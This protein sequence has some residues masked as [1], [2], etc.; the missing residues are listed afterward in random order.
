MKQMQKQVVFFLITIMMVSMLVGCS[1]E[2]GTSKETGSTREATFTGVAR[3][4]GGEV[5]VT[6]T[7]DEDKMISVIA[8]G[9]NE[10]TGIGTNALEKLP[11]A[12]LETN[13]ADV[14]AISGAT[15]TSKAIKEAAQSA[16]A[17]SRGEATAELPE[18]MMT[19]GTYV[20]QAQGYAGTLE[21][22]V[23]VS[24]NEIISIEL[25]DNIPQENEMIDR[26]FWAA[27][28]PVAMLRDTPQILK[29]VTDRLPDRIVESQSLAVDVISGATVSS[30]GFMMAVRDAIVQAGGNPAALNRPIEKNTAEEVYE[31]DVVIIG[32]GTSGTSAVAS[33]KDEG[34]SVILIEKSG[35]VGGTGSL[36]SQPMTLGASIQLENNVDIMDEDEL[37]EEWMAQNHWY[38]NGGTLRRFLQTTGSTVDWL[39]ERG[40]FNWGLS[41]WSQHW[42]VDYVDDSLGSMGV[43]DS[44][45]QLISDVDMVLYETTGKS[46]IVDSHGAVVGV[47]AEKYDGTKVTVN[48]KSVIIAT[49]GMLGNKDLMEQYNNGYSYEIF[50]LA[51]NIGEGFE[52]ALEA[53]AVEW[54]VG[55]VAAHLTDVAGRRRVGGFDI[56]DTSIPYTLSITPSLLKVNQRG[57]RFMDENAKA[58]SMNSSTNFVLANGSHN[59]T[60]VSQQQ[61]EVL[62]AEGLAGIGMDT[63][64]P[65]ANFFLQPLEPD[66]KME[67][68]EA[69][70]AAGEEIEIAYKGDTLEEL[71]EVTGMDPAT[72]VRNVE[73][74]NK[75]A[76]EG[77]DSYFNKP[78]QY[79]NH[80]GNEG[81]YYA[82]KAVPLAYS[83][84]GGVRVDEN[85]QALT[86]DGRPITGLYAVGVESIGSVLDG[87]AYPKLDG[88]AL[89]WGFNSGRIGGIEAG[90]AALK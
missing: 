73:R 30:S 59:F 18:L 69:V 54:N 65:G 55:G 20:G 10:T 11:E 85:M 53:G 66:Y 56:Y 42:I 32:G 71:A 36:S 3:G 24:E 49:G 12:I 25:T 16:I 51:Q 79:M 68:I 80:L 4:Y 47:I 46:L 26:E 2:T 82:I 86:A 72:F 50:G 88:V 27:K 39:A 64:P 6:I 33:A 63:V 13:S 61:V 37:F 74:Y 5:E 35:R 14:E 70:L 29:T 34:A 83:S 19:P 58:G 57:E 76:E 28:Y 9:D 8:I 81:P 90:K 43:A 48:A 31:A 75:M 52:M 87:V 78:V 21:V 7:F 40:G 89:G 67:N 38:V 84:L 23:E 1:Q 45:E 22:T 60:I 15:V 77:R 17:Q 62:K 44:F 41:P